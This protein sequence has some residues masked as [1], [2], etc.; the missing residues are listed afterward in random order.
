MEKVPHIKKQKPY[1]VGILASKHSAFASAVVSYLN[2]RFGN[3]L[4][5]GYC[6]PDVI[7]LSHGTPF[8]LILDRVSHVHPFF[9]AWLKIAVTNGVVVINNPFLFIVDDKFFEYKIASKLNIPVPKTVL[10]PAAKISSFPD[11][12]NEFKIPIDFEGIVKHVGL[13]FVLKPYDGY[14]W[15][16]VYII[17][18]VQEFQSV[19]YVN[20][21]VIFLAQEFIEYETYIRTICLGRKDV[22]TCVYDP[23]NRKYFPDAIIA[24]ELARLCK[25]YSIS[26]CKSLGYDINAVEFAVRDGIPY[27][28]DYLNPVPDGNPESITYQL[29]RQFVH[30]VVEMIWEKA[31][32]GTEMNVASGDLPK[33]LL[34]IFEDN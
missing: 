15:K 12:D 28:I 11:Q 21:H 26:L 4:E 5:A 31:A 16:D 2:T 18:S 9:N 7:A 27:A 32:S 34:P 24:S 1:R 30:G 19:Y 17:H 25:I 8:D 33:R 13:P 22:I 29:F 10:L 20:E 14:G 3:K 23:N 6:K